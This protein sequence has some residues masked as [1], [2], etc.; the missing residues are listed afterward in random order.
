MKPPPAQE[1]LASDTRR[2]HPRALA[3]GPRL[4]AGVDQRREEA[5][6]RR[7]AALAGLGAVLG[8]ARARAHA[9]EAAQ[10]ARHEDRGRRRARCTRRS[11]PSAPTIASRTVSTSKLTVQG[12]SPA[13]ARVSAA[14]DGAGPLRGGVPARS[15]RLVRSARRTCSRTDDG[16]HGASGGELRPRLEP[17]SARVRELRAQLGALES[18]LGRRPVHEQSRDAARLRSRGRKRHFPRGSV[19]RFVGASRSCSYSSTSWFAAFGSSIGSSS[20][21]L[22]RLLPRSRCGLTIGNSVDVSQAITPQTKRYESLAEVA[23]VS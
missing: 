10:R 15:L 7:V 19:A 20:L 3:R 17:L 4:V 22:A 12:P 13:D 11:T 9:P 18:R 16:R 21:A 2:A 14:P 5:L 1:I 23:F 6:G 8:P